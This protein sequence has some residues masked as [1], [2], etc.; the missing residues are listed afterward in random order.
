M[1][2]MLIIFAFLALAVTSSAWGAE[3]QVVLPSN[4]HSLSFVVSGLID[5]KNVEYNALRSIRKHDVF[6]IGDTVTV[7]SPLRTNGGDVIIFAQRVILKADIDTRVY[8]D[9][10]ELNPF[11][12][13]RET[14]KNR[15]NTWQTI[16]V[17]EA[18][19]K[20]DP[21][22]KYKK[23]FVQFHSFCDECLI[24]KDHVLIP[25]APS[26][27]V[28]SFAAG[29]F[30]RDVIRNG[31]AP[32]MDRFK[33]SAFNS[34]NITIIGN[35]IE[36]DAA[37][38]LPIRPST[39]PSCSTDP[40]ATHQNAFLLNASGMAGGVGGAGTPSSAVATVGTGT[41]FSCVDEAFLHVPFSGPGGPGGDA[42]HISLLLA[43][44]S[45]ARLAQ[46]KE[47]LSGYVQTDGGVP[48][49]HRK[50]Y[51]PSARGANRT[52][53]SACDFFKR[54][55]D[56]WPVASKGASGDLLI[57]SIDSKG[58]LKTLATA[59]AEKDART[60]YD[61]IDLAQR[62]NSN[63]K[64]DSVTFEQF[65]TTQVASFL[66]LVQ[67]DLA[68]NLENELLGTT[69]SYSR[70]WQNLL[71]ISRD[72]INSLPISHKGRNYLHELQRHVD[73]TNRTPLYSYL[74]RSGGLLNIND[75]NVS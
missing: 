8:I 48:G 7:G 28:P 63:L 36:R 40:T 25:R 39:F 26:G 74:F 38:P 15:Q 67:I 59:I 11:S 54:Q 21:S 33:L 61:L 72:D 12:Q 64:I 35:E 5:V 9:F 45:P 16:P 73:V 27:L 34:G 2:L 60:D 18:F 32:A 6:C 22:G 42:G 53:G 30:G 51:S 55:E 52:T 3:P 56:D 10:T 37:A 75:P 68:Q 46:L 19:R 29:C 41:T 43:N 47:S 65:L 20:Y 70:E 66:S 49:F 57:T 62:A 69:F 13:S 4:C 71:T 44:A 23:S 17:D 24:E 58:A 31:L 1:Q 14:W 50:L